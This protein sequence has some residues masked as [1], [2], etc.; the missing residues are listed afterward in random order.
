M[1]PAKFTLTLAVSSLLSM[2]AYG[3]ID[4]T[5]TGSTAFR[6]IAQDRVGALYDAGFTVTVSNSNIR[7]Y[8]G[9]MSTAIPAFASQPVTV[10]LSFSGSASGMASVQKGTPVT[11]VDP[12]SFAPVSKVPDVAL[13]D[14]F[15]G[16]ATPPIPNTAFAQRDTVGVVPF[17][18]VRS[19]GATLGGITN[20]TRDQAIELMVT[21]GLMPATFLGGTNNNLVYLAGRDSGS[22]TRISVEKDINFQGTPYLSFNATPGNPAGWAQTNGFSSGSDVATTLRLNGDAIGYLGLADAKTIADPTNA[23]PA[24]ILPYNGVTY[25]STNVFSGKYGL[26]GYEHMVSRIGLSSNQ[27]TLRNALVAA[28]T[29][30]GYQTTNTTYTVS[31]ENQNLMQVDRGTDGGTI[32]GHF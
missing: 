7:T 14:V 13:S 19:G 16:S 12:G 10:R 28:I 20:I 6:S 4:L 1:K 31:F 9:T 21:G 18:F 2:A 24:I 3:Q 11:T 15:P 30:N 29:N 23:T 25:S 27:G 5:L 8:S 26:W 32:N 22:G 17:V